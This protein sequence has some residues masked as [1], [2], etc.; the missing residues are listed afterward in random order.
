MEFRVLG[1]VE[2][3][4]EGGRRELGSRKEQCTLAVLLLSA[5]RIV[6]A[7]LLGECI[8]G[9]DP[10]VKARETLHAYISR[11]RKHL[12]DASVD[13]GVLITTAGQGYRLDIPAECVDARRF[14][15][16]AHEADAVAA[17]EPELATALLR[18][19]LALFGGEPL[20]GLAGDWAHT[21]RAGLLEGRRAVMLRHAELGLRFGRP[22][23]FIGELTELTS[24]G[25]VDQT[26]V[27]LLMTALYKAGRLPESLVVYR[28][29]R[30]RLR[31]ELGVE[32][33]HE[34]SG[35]H[36]RILRGETDPG[37]PGSAPASPAAPPPEPVPDTLDRATA[38]FTGRT[39]Q[40]NALLEAIDG[41]L[42]AGSSSVQVIAGMPG[43]GKTTLAVHLAHRLRERFPG[44][45]LQLNLRGHDPQRA[46]M[47]PGEALVALLSVIGA[48][49][50]QSA[51]HPASLDSCA[52]LWRARTAGRRVLVLLDDA[53]DADQV[54][55]LIPVAPGS[56][57]LITTRTRMTQFEHAHVCSLDAL[58]PADAAELFGNLVGAGR[59]DQPAR[60]LEVAALCAGLPLAVAV[61][62]GHFR[63]R[64]T[65]LIGDLAERLKRAWSRFDSADRDE[66]DRDGDEL[67]RP[68]RIAFDL[69]YRELSP[70]H[71]RLLR[72][73]SLHSGEQ[74][75]LHAAAALHGASADETD[76]ALDVLVG[77]NLVEETERYHYRMHDL[78]RGYAARRIRL[79]EDEA[80][81]HSAV[82]RLLD[83]YLHAAN[84]AAHALRPD[85]Q[86][87]DQD[88]NRPAEEL[89]PVDLPA[90]ALTWFS[91]EYPNILGAVRRSLEHR[92][93]E[94]AAHLS[95]ALAH[96]FDRQG[97]WHQALES[98]ERALHAWYSIGDAAGQA[99]ALTDLAESHWRVGSHESALMCA[100]TA[101]GLYR[102]LADRAGQADALLQTGRIQL[103][104]RRPVQAEESF[105]D[106]AALRK[107]LNDR[108]GLARAL[109]GLGIAASDFGSPLRSI[110][111]FEDALRIARDLRDRGIERGCLNNLGEVCQ[112][113]GRLTEAMDY[114]RLSLEIVQELGNRQQAAVL[115]N[116]IG[117]LHSRAGDHHAALDSLR[118]ALTTFQEL[119]DVR[120]E[121][122]TLVGIAQPYL[123]LQR[124]SQALIQLQ[125]A[126]TLVDQVGD[127]LLS[128]R[129]Q[130]ALG[131]V[132]RQQV[133]YPDALKAYRSALLHARRAAAPADQ[134][135]AYRRIGD[136]LAVT[137]G[138]GAARQQWRK[139]LE[140]F[141]ELRL[142]EAQEVRE[143][144]GA[145]SEEGKR[146][147]TG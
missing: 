72:R 99:G 52:A 122:E 25:P 139:A 144:L 110:G 34:L 58:E 60:L 31:R 84:R 17:K 2:L 138:A 28:E 67:T 40:M 9:D 89:P 98:H 71:Q 119:G 113:L 26:A 42:R 75:S 33:G 129:V 62:A 111:Y 126:L 116:N 20:A 92:W 83:F 65:W 6:S 36:Q 5:G 135:R 109:E 94:H 88:S 41:D 147:G 50:E 118:S 24:R 80:A 134:A 141:E 121:I 128:A 87:L 48:D 108:R 49:V 103:S 78:V 93:F 59:I 18:E 10:P 56:L 44:G 145:G 68:V 125:R 112:Q 23:R 79:D 146:S 77:R 57:V 35:L 95:H 64:P 21:T 43:A 115:A 66:D 131:A 96:Y 123:R 46:P 15:Y 51:T 29:T 90:Q 16:L 38:H 106:C 53:R 120:S 85:D 136:I 91:A 105:R 39:D 127:P 32:P 97:L 102:D 86:Q 132:Y 137:R 142:P 7:D 81:R 30:N 11:L 140:L 82:R 101:H 130:H 1:A 100:Q 22:D 27:G 124:T 14:E 117:V 114:Y 3:W 74:I 63:S 37:S 69:S 143:L 104:A 70:A 13:P 12:R 47:E 55:L 45:T 76:R 73:L 54:R 19:A 8:W 133:R 4:V 107:G 61:A